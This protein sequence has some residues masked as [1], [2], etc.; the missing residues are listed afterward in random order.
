MSSTAVAITLPSYRNTRHYAHCWRQATGHVGHW[1]RDRFKEKSLHALARVFGQL[2]S[3]WYI[4]FFHT[5]LLP[6]LLW[7]LGRSIGTDAQPFR[8]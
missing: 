3:S 5:P 8:E 2:I 7:R 4:G 1:M 6:E